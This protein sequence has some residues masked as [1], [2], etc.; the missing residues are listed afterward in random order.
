MIAVWN[1]TVWHGDIS[2]MCAGG[3][4]F[5]EFV[6]LCLLMS[7][8]YARLCNCNVQETFFFFLVGCIKRLKNHTCT[9]TRHWLISK[10]VTG[11]IYMWKPHICF[12]LWIIKYCFLITLPW[13]SCFLG[14][15]SVLVTTAQ[16]TSATFFEPVNTVI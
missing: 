1:S 14:S 10:D 9:H 3:Q 5:L 12:Y 11:N 6:F 15:Q 4:R 8:S 2:F 13:C 16:T 7:T